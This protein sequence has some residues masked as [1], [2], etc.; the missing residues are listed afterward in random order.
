MNALT[1]AQQYR[2]A[3]HPL[4]TRQQRNHSV[5]NADRTAEK[6]LSVSPN[7]A[8]PE[9]NIPRASKTFHV[10]IIGGAFAGIRAAQD[11]EEMLPPNMVTITV[12]ERRDRYFYNLGALRSVVKRDLIDLVWL[13]YHNIFRHPHNKVIQGEVASVYPNS[14]ILKDGRKL[15]FDSLLVATG[16]VYPTPCKVDSVSHKD[17]KAEQCRYFDMVRAADSILIIG[18]GPT[19]VGLAAEIATAYPTKTVTLVHSGSRLLSTDHTSNSMSRKA[20]KKLTS[21]GIKIFLNERVVIP[22]DE[23]LSST[24]ECRWL[25]TSKGRN[26][27]SNLQFLCNGITFNTSF[28]DTLDPMFKSRIIDSRTGQIQVL[29]TMQINH[30]E[31]PW[32]FSAGDVC[33]TAGEKQAYR[34]D[35]QGGHVALCMARMAQAWCQGNDRWFDV[36]LKHWQDPAQYMCVPLGPNAGV[37][38]TPWIVLGDLPTRIMKSRELFLA[39][40]YK[41]FRLEFPGISKGHRASVG[42]A[43]QPPAPVAVNHQTATAVAATAAAVANPGAAIAARAAENTARASGLAARGSKPHVPT[44][45]G[46]S[47]ALS[48][49]LAS[50]AIAEASHLDDR[51]ESDRV[52]LSR[53][54]LRRVATV[55][56]RTSTGSTGTTS[57]NTGYPYYDFRRQRRR[58]P[59]SQA[60]ESSDEGSSGDEGEIVRGA[61]SP[62]KVYIHATECANCGHVNYSQSTF[63]ANVTASLKSLGASIATTG[64]KASSRSSPLARDTASAQRHGPVLP[65][66]PKDSR[67]PPILAQHSPP[68]QYPQP[69][70]PSS[71]GTINLEQYHHVAVGTPS[72]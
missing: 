46:N 21:L 4:Y 9:M 67:S 51:L 25:K 62:T 31:L 35:S 55:S 71:V 6:H 63:S 48:K 27:F 59:S 19:G 54:M 2:S 24:L 5:S 20:H 60:S 39:R 14:V 13:P 69:G 58:R 56:S 57:N 16:S 70:T 29:P 12:I 26:V 47:Y 61:C 3:Q 50:V 1:Q 8:L 72:N 22:E 53:P 32:I 30:P 7:M 44:D 28:M 45:L 33:N 49:A 37:T 40:R 11:L 15:D 36:P 38:D 43:Q 42:E 17:G 66:Q 34:A 64:S 23:P 10:I 65:R 41:E 18:G 52:S 68:Y